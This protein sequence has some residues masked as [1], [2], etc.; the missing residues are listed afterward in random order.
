MAFFRNSAVNLL[1]LHYGIHA[2]A[3]SGG[4]AFFLVFL[5]KAGVSVPGVFVSL[6][7]ILLGRFIIRP[8]VVGLCVRWGLR[9]MVVAGTVLSALQ[10]PLLAE[11]HGLGIILAALIALAAVAD[12]VYWTTYHAYFASLGDDDHRGQQIGMRE[13]IAAIVGVA[14]PLLTGWMLVSFGPRVAFGITAA[15][16]AAAALPLLR[17]PD[18]T[19]KR[20]AAGAFRAALP[21]MLLFAADG[22]IAAG[23]VFV[24][25]IALFVSLGGRFLGY[26]GAVALAALAGAIGGL[27]LGHHIDA[28]H[29]RRAVWYAS[30][31]L[32]VIVASRA[33]A[34]GHAALAVTANALGAFGYCLYIPTMMTAVY[35]MAKRSPCTLRFHVATEGGWDAGGAVGLLVAALAT[36]LGMPL[37]ASVLAAMAGV[38][39]AGAMLWRYYASIPASTGDVRPGPAG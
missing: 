2:I 29:G 32:A 30:G 25:Q 35:T 20:Q 6:A 10:Y 33:L 26:G 13:A 11:V 3:L 21:G 7:L 39:A 9:A 24:W 18:V 23:N 31:M 22:W 4:A 17:G 16:T 5:M 12:T 28:G 38:A 14:S 1:N 36:G 34:A 27:T 15:V 37:Y 8:L 19:V